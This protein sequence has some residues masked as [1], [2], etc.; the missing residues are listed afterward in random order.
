MADLTSQNKLNV[1]GNDKKE[2]EKSVSEFFCS[3]DDLFDADLDNGDVDELLSQIDIPTTEGDLLSQPQLPKL[4]QQ[5]Q[6]QQQQ[7]QQQQQEQQHHQQQ[8]QQQ[9][10]QQ[11]QQQQ[12][13]SNNI[14]RTPILSK[15]PA[16]PSRFSNKSF[17]KKN[18]INKDDFCLSDKSFAHNIV[19]NVVSTPVEN[20]LQLKQTQQQ[21]Q[22]FSQ[23]QCAFDRPVPVIPSPAISS[24]KHNQISNTRASVEHLFEERT[25]VRSS[26]T[27]SNSKN[28]QSLS[29]QRTPCRDPSRPPNMFHR[30]MR[31]P[32]LHTPN[33]TTPNILS[34]KRKQT[35][36]LSHEK[37]RQRRFPGPAGV[38]PALSSTTSLDQLK[39]PDA[40]KSGTVSSSLG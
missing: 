36:T 29:E 14:L 27:T 26:T 39:S 5:Q 7:K 2:E 15:E 8:Q 1:G 18:N 11:Q 34:N 21:Q 16:E 6:Q 4:Q 28:I 9:H 37:P 25:P 13:H 3:G 23:H 38:L 35:T 24:L 12:Q 20:S 32:E 40:S 30:N 33:Q 17:P 31:T 10:H 19:K 22:H